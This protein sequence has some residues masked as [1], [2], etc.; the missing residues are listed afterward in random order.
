MTRFERLV[1][2]HQR[3]QH[4]RYPVSM[5]SLVEELEVAR[6]TV[7]RDFAYLRDFLGAPLV[8]DAEANGHYYDPHSPTFELPGLWLNESELYALLA[9]EELLESVQPGLLADR[10]APLK[11]RVRSLLGRGGHD[12]DTVAQRI[13]VLTPGRR[14]VDEAVFTVVAD[15]TLSARCLS[16]TY[17][18]RAR[19]ES[20][21][22]RV[23]PQR[24]VNYRNNWYL[25]ADCEQAGGLRLFSLDRIRSAAKVD[26][27][28]RLLSDATLDG[29]LEGG[30]GIFGGHAREWAVIRFTADAARWAAEERWHPEQVGAWSE[31]GRFELRLPYADPT[32]VVMEVL[33]FGA[34]A[35]VVAPATLRE[36]V[37]DQLSRAASQYC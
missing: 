35:E 21:Q 30:Y 29:F 12:Q 10:L 36:R 26:L 33:R 11:E 7:S 3:L 13:R 2:I 18:G 15:A 28:A 25:I 31:D 23:H 1:R 22:R 16:I 4:A 6:T 14:D 9:T 37:A 24:L 34:E 20:S 5:R 8:Y 19:N 32:E 27:A 17:Q